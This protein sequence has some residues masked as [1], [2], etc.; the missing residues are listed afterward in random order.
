MNLLEY[1]ERPWGSYQVLLDLPYCKVKHIT[2]KP[3]QR[4]SY[5]KHQ[6]RYERWTVIKGQATVVLNGSNKYLE[7]G[8]S[9][10]IP[11]GAA[12]RLANITS[13]ILE[14]V[15]VQMGSYFGEED[16]IRLQDDYGRGD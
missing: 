8:Q 11:L 5:Q 3:G 9:I 10:E 6:F 14:I 12:H 2:V 7:K 15:E 4:L 16:I 1:D 13:D